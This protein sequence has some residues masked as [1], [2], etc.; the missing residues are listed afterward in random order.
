MKDK[1]FPFAECVENRIGTIVYLKTDPD[2]LP[3]IIKEILISIESKQ[4]KLGCAEE[5]SWHYSFE[6]TNEK[7]ILKSFE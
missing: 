7:D 1:V 5:D 4:F 2:Q 3:R 6:F